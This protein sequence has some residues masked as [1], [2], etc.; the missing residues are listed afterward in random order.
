MSSHC[1]PE[2]RKSFAQ[3]MISQSK[4]PGDDGSVCDAKGNSY[5]EACAVAPNLT[6]TSFDTPG[7]CMVTPYS[8]GAMLIVFLLWVMRTNWVRTLISSTSWVKRPMLASSSGAS[9]SPR[10]QNGLG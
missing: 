9:T 8:T 2:R 1:P 4:D 7:S 6:D 5:A 3:R 10:M